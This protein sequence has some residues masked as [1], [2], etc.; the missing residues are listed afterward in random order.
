[1][2]PQD[3]INGYEFDNRYIEGTNKTIILTQQKF[4]TPKTTEELYTL[5]LL[6]PELLIYYRLYGF[7]LITDAEKTRG[8][9][10]CVICSYNQKR[11]PATWC[12][13]VR[14]YGF[15][16]CN[17]CKCY[18]YA[19]YII[20]DK[21]NPNSLSN[22]SGATKL[23]TEFI[24][25]YNY[26]YHNMF[27]T[28][29]YFYLYSYRWYSNIINCYICSQK[30]NYKAGYCKNCYD[31]IHTKFFS[32]YTPGYMIIQKCP[33]VKELIYLLQYYYLALLEFQLDYLDI[34]KYHEPPKLLDTKVESKVEE[35]EEDS[36]SKSD[37]ITLDNVDEFLKS[38]SEDSDLGYYE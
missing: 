18:S 37:W 16:T 20:E 31:Y 12:L 5:N 24:I 22:I 34:V 11:T 23:S 38:L 4:K 21:S 8:D 1:M 27:M 35:S 17:Y 2:D 6:Y 29:K 7:S 36:E 9:Y 10:Y 14:N 32:R 19:A 33:L 3:I 28:L 26:S 15:S 13:S 25:Y 30:E